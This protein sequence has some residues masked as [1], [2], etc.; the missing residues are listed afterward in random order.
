MAAPSKSGPGAVEF[1]LIGTSMAAVILL[2]TTIMYAKNHGEAAAVAEAAKKAES[3]A[4]GIISN[5]QAD[6]EAI[7]KQLGYNQADVG[8]GDP[9]GPNTVR[10]NLDRDLKASGAVL[11]LQGKDPNNQP[12]QPIP[13][14]VNGMLLRLRTELDDAI[15]ENAQLKA[16]L[17]IEKDQFLA[18]KA[19]NNSKVDQFKQD[20]AKSEG[21]LEK[22]VKDRDE[23]ARAKDAEI[24]KWQQ[25]YRTEQIEKEQIRDEAARKAK[26]DAERIARLNQVVDFQRQRLEE[27]QNVSFDVADGMVTNVDNTNAT[28]WLNLGKKDGLRP[29]VTFAVYGKTNKGIARGPEDV[30]AKIEIV[31]VRETS[32]IARIIDEE[33]DRPVGIGDEVFS[34]AWNAG[35]TEYFAL[36]GNAD[37][38]R[39]G[40]LDEKDRKI[41]KDQLSNAGAQIEVEVTS[42][43]VR[44]PAD[45]KITVQTKWLIV[46]DVG[47]PGSAIG[48]DAKLQRILAVQKQHELLVQEAREHGIRIV[49]MKDFLTYL[50]W[51][52]ESRLYIPGSDAPFTLQ[53][54]SRRA[55][56]NDYNRASNAP[57]S[58]AIQSKK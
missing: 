33:R 15:A 1:S 56:F 25:S 32:S 19:G 9:P 22:L 3:D 34:P 28:V 16:N 8:V 47:D 26:E 48:D 54:G 38:N 10:E 41:L 24:A 13:T 14:T 4:N 43:G 27:I 20:K 53:A 2:A 17:T 6:I 49:S 7:K 12:E 45:A 40:V 18:F 23:M 44:E 30:K 36:V 46:G 29:Q 39:D 5:L 57:I 35:L 37:L 42:D 52:P 51:K 58:K 31:E 50:G 55:G 11:A 21:D